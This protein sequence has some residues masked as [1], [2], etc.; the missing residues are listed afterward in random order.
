MML[1]KY[2]YHSKRVPNCEILKRNT[3]FVRYHT[4]LVVRSLL[5]ASFEPYSSL[6]FQTVECAATTED[7]PSEFSS[8]SEDFPSHHA[9]KSTQ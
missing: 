4:I 3:V 1:G 8:L 5:L 7:L 2:S 6:I 9:R